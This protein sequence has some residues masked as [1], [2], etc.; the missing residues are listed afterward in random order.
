MNLNQTFTVLFWQ[1]K[2]RKLNG[3]CMVYARVTINGRRI[4]ISTN[5]KIPEKH[6]NAKLQRAKG[7]SH[8][9]KSLNNHLDAMKAALYQHHSRLLTMG[10]TVTPLL[11]K[12]EYFGIS[13]DRKTLNEAFDF[14]L[15]QYSDKV[16]I[17][18]TSTATLKKYQYTFAKTQSFVQNKYRA[19]DMMLSDIGTNFLADFYHYLFTEEKLS[20]NTSMKY[21]SRV[22]TLFLVANGRGWMKSNL[23]AT[24][25][26][27]YEEE[28][29]NRLEM[30]E[31]QILRNKSF[32]IT[33]LAEAKD[34]FVFMCYTGFAY[35]DVRELSETNLF[36]GID[37]GI[38]VAK[39][40]KKTKANECVPL[41]PP[42][43]KIL[44]KYR[45]HPYCKIKNVLLPIKSNQKFNGY[46]KE[47]ADLC[48]IRKELSTHAAR[49]TFATTVTLE[50]DMPLETVS[51]MLGHR[52]LKTTQRYAKVTNKKIS[53]NM[54]LLKKK[55]FL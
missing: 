52:S 20:N 47:I 5:R 14:L 38:W 43:L 18:K 21:V 44:E 7:I 15:K 32:T 27:S 29:P 25:K 50:N 33:R 40:R 30:E 12:N 26:C 24:F 35:A 23:A 34:C 2:S 17:G 36:K 31:L 8:E 22:K 19:S 11:L 3:Q 49:H 54:Q 37:G 42:A 53:D 6:W 48:G 13:E 1:A 45:E 55:L 46:L 16:N 41:L 51:K 39:N 4:E 10:K 9:V 28:N